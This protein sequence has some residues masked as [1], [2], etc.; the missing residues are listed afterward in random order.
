MKPDI[1]SCHKTLQKHIHQVE[2][3]ESD[4]EALNAVKETFI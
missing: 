4:R 3:D 2:K 1:V